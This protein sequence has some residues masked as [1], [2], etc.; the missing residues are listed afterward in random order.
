MKLIAPVQLSKRL[1]ERGERVDRLG[2]TLSG[3]IAIWHTRLARHR[4][5]IA[6]LGG[7]LAGAAFALRWRSL[8]RVT[9]LLAGA[10]VR[11]TALSAVTRVRVN[12]VVRRE[13]SRA[14]RTA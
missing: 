3:T 14:T 7:G 11:A 12:R 6:M 8:L 13:W 5:A 9:A 10:V 1:R 4:M 2:R